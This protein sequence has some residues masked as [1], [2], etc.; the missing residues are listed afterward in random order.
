MHSRQVMLLVG[1]ALLIAQVNVLTS[2]GPAIACDA[3]HPCT[4]PP[5]V[6][7]PGRG[8]GVGIWVNGPG[9]TTPSPAP[10]SGGGG[11]IVPVGGGNG[12][13][14]GSAAP[15]PLPDCAS[16]G[17][18]TQCTFTFGGPSTGGLWTFNPPP[19]TPAPNAPPVPNAPPPSIVLALNAFG[20]LQMPP[21]KP[22][23][24]PT[25]I[26]K[27]SGHPYT[28]V[29]ANTWFWTDPATFQPVSKTVTAGAVWGRATA[30]PVSLTFTPGDDGH[31]VT[32]KGPGTAWQ[33]NDQTWLPPANP[34]GCSY[35]YPNSSLGVGGDDQVTATYTITWTVTWAGSDGTGGAFNGMQTQTASRFAVAEAQT[36][37]VR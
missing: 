14:G 11:P 10:G 9:G 26:L 12:G 1:A 37:V 28:V 36:V 20:Q 31:P 4:P 35:Q 5:V 27:E 17:A 15:P 21:P 18:A 13:G 16:V 23:R 7:E 8:S 33:P 34:Q 2:A 30:T 32:C 6:V 3:A 24:Y 29:N 19:G 25:G 22:S